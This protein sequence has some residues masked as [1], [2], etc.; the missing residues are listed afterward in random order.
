MVLKS[1]LNNHETSDF[2]SARTDLKR[3]QLEQ[4]IRWYIRL[5]DIWPKI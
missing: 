5:L 3:V 2:W 1:I 4:F